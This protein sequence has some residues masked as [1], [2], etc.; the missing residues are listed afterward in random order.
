MVGCLLS[1]PE[2]TCWLRRDGNSFLEVLS[3][4]KLF[5]SIMGVNIYQEVSHENEAVVGHT[6]TGLG[7]DPAS[8]GRFSGGMGLSAVSEG[9]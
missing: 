1:Q 7:L 6:S 4:S 3:L 8:P 2:P 5:A 9:T